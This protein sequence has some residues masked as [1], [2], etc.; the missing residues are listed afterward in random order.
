MQGDNLMTMRIHSAG[1][2]ALLC[3]VAQGA[4]DER[5]QRRIWATARAILQHPDVVSAIP[6]VNNLL[7]GFNG[8]SADPETMRAAITQ[9]WEAASDSDLPANEIHIQVEYGGTL[10]EDLAD[11]ASNAG[12]SVQQT[13]DLHS[14]GTY[15]VAAVGAM[16][17]FVYLTGLD[18]RLCLPRRRTPRIHVPRGAVIIG[19]GQA[20]V[21]PCDAPSGW[22]IIGMT[23]TMLF[24]IHRDEVCLLKMGDIVRFD[25]IS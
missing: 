10:A 5:A 21:M 16:P 20:G 7:V 6:G 25:A 8:L 3:D 4:F 23:D 18:K 15:R 11:V 22:H 24:D 14:S 12:L 2:T 13:I 19:G 1:A 9:A 17:G